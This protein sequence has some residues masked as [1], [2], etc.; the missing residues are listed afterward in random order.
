MTFLSLHLAGKLNGF[1]GKVEAGESVLE[2]ALRELEEE[3]EIQAKDARPRGRL[4]F[5]FEG[6]E[7]ILDVRVFSATE[8]DGTPTETEEMTAEWHSAKAMPYDEM[9][10]PSTPQPSACMP[11]HEPRP[12]VASCTAAAVQPC[13]PQPS[14][15]SR[16]PLCSG[17]TTSTGCPTFSRGTCSGDTSCSA[18]TR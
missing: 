9:V 6:D 11:P 7:T 10:R 14:R 17:R 13:V 12:A 1:G 5:E 8:F 15:R 18:G 16:S 4:L 3:A 2:G